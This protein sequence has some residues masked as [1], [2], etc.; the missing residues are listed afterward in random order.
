[1]QLGAIFDFDGV[2]FHSDLAHE[3][4]WRAVAESE[5]RT[6]SRQDFLRGFGV[7]NERFIR[8]ILGWTQDPAEVARL[9]QQKERIFHEYVRKNGL[10]PIFGTVDLVERLTKRK[11]PCAIGSSAQRSNIDLILAPYPELRAAFAICVTGED[12]HS[13][14]PDPEVF[15][16][17]AKKLRLPPAS[18]VVFEDAPL[19]IKA[20]KAAGMKVV[21]LETSFPEKSLREALPDL[22]VQSLASVTVQDL[23][24]LIQ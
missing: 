17:A 9:A 21:A 15:L 19:G 18:C 2:L 5:G 11:V 16:L 14:K 20:G 4:C 24:N 7:K 13:G 12:V 22:L 3:A 8:E 1:M 10:E 6:F 23:F